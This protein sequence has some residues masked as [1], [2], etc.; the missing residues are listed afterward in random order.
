MEAYYNE[1]HRNYS[2]LWNYSV[3]GNREEWMLEKIQHKKETKRKVLDRWCIGKEHTCDN[4]EAF[5]MNL[6]H[7]GKLSDNPLH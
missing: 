2:V 1:H 3:I 6:G 4:D 5:D 7:H